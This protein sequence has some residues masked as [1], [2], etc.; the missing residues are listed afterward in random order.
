VVVVVVVVVVFVVVVVVVVVV[1]LFLWYQRYRCLFNGIPRNNDYYVCLMNYCSTIKGF[2]ILP[3]LYMKFYP[4]M[5]TPPYCIL[6][7][8]PALVLC[9]STQ[10]TM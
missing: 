9:C 7:T 5:C 2:Y 8:T 3:L 10:N 1:V 4:T 6:F